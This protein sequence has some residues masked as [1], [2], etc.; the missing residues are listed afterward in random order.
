ML[1][2]ASILAAIGGYLL[3]KENSADTT[4]GAAS[5]L[6]D[7]N[8]EPIQ[9]EDTIDPRAK[10]SNHTGKLVIESLNLEV[11]LK[12]LEVPPESVI[13]PPTLT[14]AFVIT[15]YGNLQEKTS[16]AVFITMHAVVGGR[17]PG[18]YLFDTSTDPSTVLIAEGDTVL[19]DNQTYRVT[20]V[21]SMTKAEASKS[22]EVWGNREV[23]D[24]ELVIITCLQQP[25]NSPNQHA[26]DNLVVFAEQVS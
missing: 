26:R 24:G 19:A 16:G 21:S 11:P 5:V 13:V 3:L 14:D 22:T 8:G 15:N 4:A 20:K 10:I 9:L 6:E 18:N 1:L 7:M 12:G 23:R 25:G 2:G 17:A